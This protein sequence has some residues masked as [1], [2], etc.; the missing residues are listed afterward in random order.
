MIVK[1]R[2][3]QEKYDAMINFLDSIIKNPRYTAAFLEFDPII[4]E[5]LNK[6]KDFHNTLV[7]LYDADPSLYYR[8]ENL[9]DEIDEGNNER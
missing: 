3:V 1:Q 5:I 7:N 4:S 2:I 6:I 9:P 8:E